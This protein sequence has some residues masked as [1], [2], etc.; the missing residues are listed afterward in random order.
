MGF[1]NK[2]NTTNDQATS[3]KNVVTSDTPI[4][5]SWFLTK[6]DIEEKKL[7]IK[8]SDKLPLLDNGV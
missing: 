2:L 5:V 1:G 7:K 8:T 6:E 4:K 3:S